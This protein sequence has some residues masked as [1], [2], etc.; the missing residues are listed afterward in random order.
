MGCGDYA[1]SAGTEDVK[2]RASRNLKKFGRYE[3]K[4]PIC[5]DINTKKDH[6]PDFKSWDKTNEVTFKRE[7]VRK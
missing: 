5:G 7:L 2:R 4:C 3:V 6:C 1:R